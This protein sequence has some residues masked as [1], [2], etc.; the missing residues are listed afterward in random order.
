MAYRDLNV[1]LFLAVSI[2]KRVNIPNLVKKSK[3]RNKK[4][5]FI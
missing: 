1:L 2:H 5:Y 3:E 4:C